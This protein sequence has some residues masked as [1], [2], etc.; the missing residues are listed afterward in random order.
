[1]MYLIH[2]GLLLAASFA[3]YW[4]LLRRETHFELNRYILLACLAASLTL[5]LVTVPAAWSLKNH[6][7]SVE[8]ETTT[9]PAE[10]STAELLAKSAAMAE[11]P[12]QTDAPA[13]AEPPAQRVEVAEEASISPIAAERITR[14]VDWWNIVWWVY[15]AGF[16]VFGAHFLIQA[17][18]LLV[19][20]LRNP[21]F[22]A[23]GFH[24]VE[25]DEDAAPYSFWN[26]VFLNPNR[27]DPD[28]FHQIVQHEAVHVRQRHSLDLLIAEALVVVQWFNPFAWWYRAAIENNLEFLT[29]AEVLRQGEDPIDYQM[30]LLKVAVPNLPLGLTTSYNQKLLEKRISMMKTKRS[31][32]RSGWKYL[33]ILPLF[34]LSMLQFNAVAQSPAPPVPPAPTAAPVPAPAPVVSVAPAPT[35]S[36]AETP[37]ATPAPPVPVSPGVP[38]VP[39][40]APTPTLNVVP[41][42]APAPMPV[43]PRITDVNAALNSWTA[44]IEGNEICIQFMS[45]NR[46]NG[47]NWNWNSQRC[48]AMSEI[49]GG[50]PRGGEVGSFAIRRT[51]GEMSMKGTFEGNEGFGTF[52][53]T[54]SPT[55]SRE[56]DR[57]GYRG[58]DDQ[59]MM[60]LFM[61]DVD[62]EY[63]TYLDNQGYGGDKEAL[64]EAA[65][66]FKDLKD[67]QGRVAALRQRGYGQV[68]F[69]KLVEL[70]IH[71]VT[72]DYINYMADAGFGKLS[73]NDLVKAK[74]HGVKPGYLEGMAK[75]GFTG[76]NFDQVLEMS[77]H[78]VDVDY[79]NELN[80]LGYKNLSAQE[81]V[82]ARIHGVSTRRIADMKSA[83][84]G[85]LTLDQAKQMTIHGVDGEYVQMLRKNGFTSLTVDEIVGAKIHG[86]SQRRL[87][88]IMATGLEVTNFEDVKSATIHGVDGE[89]IDGLRKLG[90]TDMGMQD[91]ISARIHGVTPRFAQSIQEAGLKNVTAKE[92]VKLRIHGVTGEFIKNRKDK[93]SSA[94]DFIKMKIHG[95]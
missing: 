52:T 42:P 35:V 67:I 94:E 3:Y 83:G 15:L 31:S 5:P 16:V 7:V 82:A 66:F 36:P 27:Y 56:L 1:M 77:I 93:G 25:I 8:A 70:Q 80:E 30:S 64:L 13:R 29:D 2:A 14:T 32:L 71:G 22:D 18:Y 57:L 87:D 85:D 95:R 20:V 33:S 62:Q 19:K 34:L 46:S 60:L 89:F 40:P 54:A 84:L 17:G 48:F 59:E 45:K 63:L 88:A 49:S 21:G 73:L 65:I 28:T 79:V 51:A 72:E 91:F 74:I 24:L 92:L 61:A 41:V 39:A 53:W 78:G 11:N 55:F 68:P 76:L 38:T 9:A 44:E 6:I 50:L 69:N 26:R 37:N 81:V 86:V 12:G 10:T 23:G 47:N 58:F 4:L 75:A 90:Y 43:R